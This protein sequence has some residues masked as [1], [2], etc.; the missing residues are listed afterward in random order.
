MYIALIF[1]YHFLIA[2]A[3]AYISL[4]IRKN[5]FPIY[6]NVVVSLCY[7][8]G[9]ILSLKYLK[10]DLVKIGS[11]VDFSTFSGFY[12]GLYLLGGTITVNQF[13][14]LLLMLIGVFIINKDQNN[15]REPKLSILYTV[16]FWRCI[17]A[18]APTKLTS[19]NIFRMLNLRKYG[20]FAG[21]KSGTLVLVL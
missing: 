19:G 4:N 15:L 12:I 16:P 18:S 9:W 13:I 5:N 21:V 17:T 20:I 14:G 10:I 8:L 6:S 3:A 7:A 1:I 2:V 11:L